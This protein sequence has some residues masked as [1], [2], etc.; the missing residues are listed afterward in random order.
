MIVQVRYLICTSDFVLCVQTALLVLKMLGYYIRF[1][2]VF[3]K[4]NFGFLSNDPSGNPK[5]KKSFHFLWLIFVLGFSIICT[6]FCFCC[7]IW[8]FITLGNSLLS[9]LDIVNSRFNSDFM[10]F[11]TP[12][13]D[14]RCTTSVVWYN[15]MLITFVFRYVVIS[16]CFM[17]CAGL[18]LIP[19]DCVVRHNISICYIGLGW[20]ILKLWSSIIDD[21]FKINYSIDLLELD[22]GYFGPIWYK[23]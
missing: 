2:S 19:V 3:L 6:I 5:D 18:F 7:F 1:C 10:A 16:V 15:L 22:Y 12:F 14:V 8:L 4:L 20:E 13:W 21:K 9:T 11:Y 17:V 23:I